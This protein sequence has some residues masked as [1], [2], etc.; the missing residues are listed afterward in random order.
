MEQRQLGIVERTCVCLSVCRSVCFPSVR[1]SVCNLVSDSNLSSPSAS[2]FPP[3]FWTLV[4][5]RREKEELT[6]RA[7]DR[8]INYW[9]G[10]E[11]LRIRHFFV[12]PP[13]SLLY[14]YVH[15]FYAQPPRY[16][17]SSLIRKLAIKVYVLKYSRKAFLSL[18][19]YVTWEQVLCDNLCGIPVW[20]RFPLARQIW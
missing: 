17:I 18:C 19:T 12:L 15:F 1:L 16:R 4:D 8:E 14:F 13:G 20:L 6:E 11:H 10:N 9:D 2:C 3:A 7:A 5:P